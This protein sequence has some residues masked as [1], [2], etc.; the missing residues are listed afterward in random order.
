VHEFIAEAN[1]ILMNQVVMTVYNKKTY[2]VGGVELPKC[3]NTPYKSDGTRETFVEYY[4]R[5]LFFAFI[6]IVS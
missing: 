3:L 6:E 1:A 4:K 2:T 5:V